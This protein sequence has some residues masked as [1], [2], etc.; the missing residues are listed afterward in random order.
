MQAEK[1]AQMEELN[2]DQREKLAK[3]EE[4]ISELQELNE[5]LTQNL[6]NKENTISELQVLNTDLK[7]QMEVDK[8]KY[9]KELQDMSVKVDTL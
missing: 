4:T 2:E 7:R 6:A 3:K 1:I 5:D 9:S 8:E